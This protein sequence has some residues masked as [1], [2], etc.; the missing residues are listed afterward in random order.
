MPR[1][2]IDASCFIKDNS[3]HIGGEN[4]RHITKSLRMRP[5]ESLTLC[6]GAGKDYVCKLVSADTD[7]ARAAIVSTEQNR[8]EPTHRLTVYQCLPKAGKLETIVQKSVELGASA[9]IPV[10]SKRCV[11]R[12]NEQRN[13]K[14]TGRLQKIALEAAKQ[15]GRG[16]IPAVHMPMP[17]AKAAAVAQTEGSS[18]VFYEKGGKALKT[19][20][21]TITG[22]IGIFIGPEGGF[23]EEEIELLN[24]N[25][26]ITATL[27][28]RILR[29]ET[30]PITALSIILYEMGEM[31]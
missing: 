13:E 2:F 1:F 25:G 28:P 22:N 11:A 3:I 5:G 30:A 31:Q 15:S 17:L 9:I 20:L 4:A 7:S 14:K 26:V 19:I 18:I 6:D 27:G 10:L 21:P 16:I 12:P 23:A 8:T 29:T 24:H